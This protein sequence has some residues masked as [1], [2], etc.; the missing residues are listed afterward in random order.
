MFEF[1]A[2]EFFFFLFAIVGTIVGM[3]KWYRPLA[4]ATALHVPASHQLLLALVPI[5]GWLLLGIVL[6]NWSDPVY[7]AGHLDYTLLFMFG[8]GIWMFLGISLLPWV[9]I[10]WR[11][12]AVGRHNG[13]A[14]VAVCGA[15]LGITIAYAYCNIG[16]GPTISTTLVPA[17]VAGLTLFVLFR[18]V[19]AIA[20]PVELV[21]VERD[22]A[23]GLRTGA[24]FIACAIVLGRAM[25]GDFHGWDEV[26][27]TYATF[28][29]PAVFFVLIAAACDRLFAPRPDQPH[30]NAIAFG[31]VPGLA[32]ILAA[33]VFVGSLGA[34]VVAPP[35]QYHVTPTVERP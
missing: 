7:V 34:P 16:N 33:I 26:F 35:G 13:A 32:M 11:D 15:M 31:L 12:D 21:T 14:V 20:D 24:F 17:L 5:V 22:L 19:E 9:G 1:S 2:P 8:G 18:M 23:A 27:I 4:T 3:V 28:G 25:A 30:P 6:Q 29:W 10:S